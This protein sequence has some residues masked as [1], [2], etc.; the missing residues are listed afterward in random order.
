MISEVPFLILDNLMQEIVKSNGLVDVSRANEVER[1]W[2][3]VSMETGTDFIDHLLEKPDRELKGLSALAEHHP[4][5][6]TKLVL[7]SSAADASATRCRLHIWP[8]QEWPKEAIHNHRFNFCATVLRGSYIHEVYSV[9]E[10][11]NTID[12]VKSEELVVSPGNVY[13]F[14]SG[15]YHRIVPSNQTTISLL[16]R[17]PSILE[18]SSVV[19]LQTGQLR[20]VFGTNATFRKKLKEA[21][22]LLHPDAQ[23]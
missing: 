3:L 10:E 8:A 19:D 21:R 14:E 5:G 13:Y 17:G 15:L 11:N 16:V 7:W 12:V 23:V 6:F 22:H 2:R 4:L 1:L 18:H 20:H 9:S